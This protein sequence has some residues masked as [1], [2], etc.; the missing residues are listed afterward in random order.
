M[1]SAFT[2][3]L[4]RFA[5]F[6]CKL[7]FSHQCHTVL[8]A[9]SFCFMTVLRHCCP[10][11]QDHV[12]DQ[13][14]K[15]AVINCAEGADLLTETAVLRQREVVAV[16]RDPRALLLASDTGLRHDLV[17]TTC[18]FFE[19]HAELLSKNLRRCAHGKWL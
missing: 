3:H 10:R 2:P 11:P 7:T 18:G 5:A 1:S 8:G 12:T 17:F 16:I 14:P 13:D 6:Y 15:A 9:G 19:G 4:S